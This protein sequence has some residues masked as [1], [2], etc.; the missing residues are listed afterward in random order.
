MNKRTTSILQ[1]IRKKV[2]SVDPQAEVILYGSRARGDEHTDSDWDILI[3]TDYSVDVS[4]EDKFRDVLYD[5][6]LETEESLSVFVFSKEEW[7]NKQRITPFY[8]NVN[9][10][11]ITL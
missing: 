11:G 7:H 9:K 10:E 5:L 3:I 6:E 2:N 1:L 4:I 8:E